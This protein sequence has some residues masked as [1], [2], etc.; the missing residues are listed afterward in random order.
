[1]YAYLTLVFLYF[2]QCL[3]HVL[4]TVVAAVCNQAFWIIPT[5]GGIGG[6][7]LI[8]DELLDRKPSLLRFA[9]KLIQH[10]RLF[11]TGRCS[12]PVV[13]WTTLGSV[14]E[15]SNLPSGI[16][17]ECGGGIIG[18]VAPSQVKPIK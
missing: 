7:I 14:S 5:E 11:C 9:K 4:G 16:V 3:V 8:T 2:F 1:M 12:H 18:V 10:V 15:P 17:M 6:R 13:S